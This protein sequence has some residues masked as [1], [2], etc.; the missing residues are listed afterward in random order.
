M[1]VVTLKLFVKIPA[2]N[3]KPWEIESPSEIERQAMFC[4]G[5]TKYRNYC[6]APS[7]NLFQ[8]EAETA[9]AFDQQYELCHRAG[10]TNTWIDRTPSRAV[11]G[12]LRCGS[13]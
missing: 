13:R 1:R 10:I 12:G 3:V 8:I 5:G 7:A 9:R 4:E 6:G 2:V 11:T